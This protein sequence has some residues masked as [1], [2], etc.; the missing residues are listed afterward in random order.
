MVKDREFQKRCLYG[1]LKGCFRHALSC[2]V[3][4]EYNPAQ[5]DDNIKAFYVELPIKRSL[6]SKCRLDLE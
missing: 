3:G 1:L 6:I 5:S 2:R 4:R